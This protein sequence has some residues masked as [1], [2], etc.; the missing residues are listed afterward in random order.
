MM[1]GYQSHSVI[2]RWAGVNAGGARNPHLA[3]Q[4]HLYLQEDAQ[5]V[6]T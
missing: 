6:S 5:V 4:F 2:G 1:V 3:P